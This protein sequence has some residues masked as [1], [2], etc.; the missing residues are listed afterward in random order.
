MPTTLPAWQSCTVLLTGAPSPDQP[1][2]IIQLEADGHAMQWL[3][4]QGERS[5]RF[6][7]VFPGSYQVSAATHLDGKEVRWSE[8]LA[9][10]VGA[11]EAASATL[12]LRQP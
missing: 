10:E 6:E 4:S 1:P 5:V 12:E 3:P 2:L 8:T 11:E 9:V 7:V